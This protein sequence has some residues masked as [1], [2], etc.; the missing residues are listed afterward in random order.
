M[1]NQ[2]CAAEFRALIV[3]MKKTLKK[4]QIFVNANF[5]REFFNAQNILDENFLMRKNFGREFWIQCARTFRHS[6][7]P[8]AP[9]PKF[10]SEI[11]VH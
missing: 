4:I 1:R 10:S 6:Q 8:C 5:G 9:N 11:S 7:G 2:K 3:F